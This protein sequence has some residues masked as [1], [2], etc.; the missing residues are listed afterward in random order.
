MNRPLRQL[1]CGDVVSVTDDP[2]AVA[3]VSLDVMR[4]INTALGGEFMSI[5]Y[6]QILVFLHRNALAGRRL[7]PVGELC[8]LI[9]APYSTTVRRIDELA[10]KGYV[11]KAVDTLDKRRINIEISD[12]SA[13]IV[14]RF[15]TRFR[16]AIGLLLREPQ[17]A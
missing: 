1:Q 2:V 16:T 12:R 13:A 3:D 11:G 9:G 5:E 17:D 10:K 15:V 6:F 4:S 14:G 7:V 8:G